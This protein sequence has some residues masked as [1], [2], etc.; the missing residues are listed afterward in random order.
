MRRIKY[1]IAIMVILSL[2]FLSSCR[3]DRQPKEQSVSSDLISDPNYETTNNDVIDNSSDSQIIE[4]EEN[5]TLENIFVGSWSCQDDGHTLFFDYSDDWRWHVHY[6]DDYDDVYGYYGITNGNLEMYY[7][8]GELAGNVYP[9]DD[10]SIR[11]QSVNDNE[12]ILYK[13]NT[14]PTQENTPPENT[15]GTVHQEDRVTWIEDSHGEVAL[16]SADG[17]FDRIIETHDGYYLLYRDDSTFD[18]LVNMYGVYCCVDNTWALPY[19]ELDRE[20]EYFG[21]NVYGVQKSRNSMWESDSGDYHFYSLDANN[22]FDIDGVIGSRFDRSRWFSQ[23][24]N[25]FLCEGMTYIVNKNG[26]VGD[27]GRSIYYQDWITNHSNSSYID[28]Y[29]NFGSYSDGGIVYICDY[30]LYFLDCDNMN[31]ILIYDDIDRIDGL[32]SANCF[33]NVSS[34]AYHDG[35]LNLTLIGANYEKYYATIDK[36]GNYIEEPHQ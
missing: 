24:Y 8:E 27:F 10:E 5:S 13:T 30:K 23:E 3:N 1:L 18:S 9:I 34:Y 29:S 4:K 33:F 20:P 19:Q 32:S 25:V 26:I 36:Q 28:V 35:A 21:G 7:D 15:N 14:T 2:S 16:S 17:D 22:E 31:S 12:I 6:E 11:F